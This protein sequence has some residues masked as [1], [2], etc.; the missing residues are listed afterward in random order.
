MVVK[1][2]HSWHFFQ[3]HFHEFTAITLYVKETGDVFEVEIRAVKCEIGIMTED[4][5]AHGYRTNLVELW[6]AKKTSC[7]LFI[8]R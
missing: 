5:E 1:T 8:L 3:N 7:V 4:H 6:E 2:G